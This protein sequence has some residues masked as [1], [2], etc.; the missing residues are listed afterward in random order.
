[1]LNIL[2][3]PF[4]TSKRINTGKIF[5]FTVSNFHR[6]TDDQV[7]GLENIYTAL[8]AMFLRTSSLQ[9]SILMQ[10]L[11]NKSKNFDLRNQ[12]NTLKDSLLLATMQSPN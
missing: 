12:T 9:I 2:N 11:T 6:A 1:M 10:L 8:A 5:F 3:C 7:Q 4:L